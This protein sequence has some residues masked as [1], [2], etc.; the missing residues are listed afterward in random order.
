[1]SNAR[2]LPREIL[3]PSGPRVNASTDRH[4]E[5]KASANVLPFRPDPARVLVNS[6]G[7][8]PVWGLVAIVVTTVT[9]LIARLVSV[10]RSVDRI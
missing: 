1:M 10:A 9:T 7:D 4:T 3:F 2:R 5:K 6:R 8:R